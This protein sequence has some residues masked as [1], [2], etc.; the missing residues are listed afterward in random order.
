MGRNYIKVSL[1]HGKRI[2]EGR[3]IPRFLLFFFGGGAFD[4]CI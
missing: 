1:S 3:W 4:Y 2:F